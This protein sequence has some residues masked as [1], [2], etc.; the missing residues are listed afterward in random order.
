MVTSLTHWDKRKR[1]LKDKRNLPKSSNMHNWALYSKGDRIPLIAQAG[2]THTRLCLPP[3]T[4]H[5]HIYT[6]IHTKKQTPTLKRDEHIQQDNLHFSK[7][8]MHPLYLW[9]FVHTVLYPDQFQ[10]TH[11]D[12]TQMSLLISLRSYYTAT[13]NCLL[14]CVTKLEF[15]LKDKYHAAF[16][17]NRT[18][19]TI[20]N[21]NVN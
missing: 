9:L 19:P 21:S 10:L 13:L 17:F 7:C 8:T 12:H 3:V 1:Q 2:R 5:A 11:L 6:Q 14:T 15:E 18:T 16:S 20:I 4:L